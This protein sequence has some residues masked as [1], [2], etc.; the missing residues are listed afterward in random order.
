MKKKLTPQEKVGVGA[1][2]LVLFP[3]LLTSEVYKKSQKKKYKKRKKKSAF[4]R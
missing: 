2:G 4:L 3:F 1:V